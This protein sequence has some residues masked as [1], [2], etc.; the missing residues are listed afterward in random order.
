M[1]LNGSASATTHSKAGQVLRNR[2]RC[3]PEVDDFLVPGDL[4]GNN[5]YFRFGPGVICY[6]RCSSGQPGKSLADPMPDASEHVRAN[7]SSVH[8]PFD[9]AQVVE[10]LCYERY[11]GDLARAPKS[12]VGQGTV[13]SL[14]YSIRPLLPVSIRKHI[15]KIY[16]RD[17]NSLPFPKWPVDR[18]VESLSEQL[19]I[20]SMKQQKIQRLPFV[21]F[22]PEGVP[23]CTIMT[24]DVETPAGVAFCPNLMDLNDSFAIKSSF[25]VVP[26]KRYPVPS[27][28]LDNIRDR[29]FEVNVQDLNHDGL[30][31]S[32]RAEFLRRAEQINAYGKKFRA[33]GFR[34]GVLY[35]NPDW[36]H[37]LHFSYDMSVPNVAH[38]DPQ[39]GGCCT[40]M[41][42]FIGD[43]V[44]LPVTTTQDYTLFH[45]L[46]D[47][48]IRLWKEQIALIREK[49][50]LISFII[51]PDYIIDEKP[52]GVYTELL[53]HLAQLRSDG[54]TWIALP[55]D[56]AEWW[57]LRSQMEV[58]NSGNSWR[59]VG[60]G[61]ERARLAYAVLANDTLTY[62]VC[63]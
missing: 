9:P 57:R 25:Q 26:E 61:S 11:A 23:S 6:G 28:Y 58:V 10:N 16:F 32:D 12:V 1:L 24:H 42:F 15:Q 29:G 60:K 59:V 53:C 46:N 7:G 54:Q 55:R 48:S 30:L 62:E 4:S 45:I 43:M 40:V 18:T 19:L 35:R 47:Y 49:H 37:A 21:W 38:L 17:W 20:L 31:Y 3:S 8:L 33:Q 50:G 36:A 39:R 5:G 63:A 22:W 41:P 52:R 2:F 34:A 56:V 51:H 27:A 44:E 13:R 14:Y